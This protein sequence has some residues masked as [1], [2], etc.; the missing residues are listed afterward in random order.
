MC[1][2]M[3]I[4]VPNYITARVQGNGA[5]CKRNLTQIGQALENYAKEHEGH[6]PG[7][8]AVLTKA[9]PRSYLET[10]PTCPAVGTVTYRDYQVT[11][12]P[13]AF[14]FS[15]SGNNHASSTNFRRY[16]SREGIVDHP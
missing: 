14:S 7:S 1:G 12:E 6:Y 8:L 2:F 3:A 5:Q 9:Q 13:D 11:V 4:L 16:N 15:C 10:L